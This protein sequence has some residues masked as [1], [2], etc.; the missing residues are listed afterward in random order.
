MK[1]C[2]CIPVQVG[3]ILI[4]IVGLL[5]CA[6]ELTLLVPYLMNPDACKNTTSTNSITRNIDPFKEN[7]TS[8]MSITGNIDPIKETLTTNCTSPLELIGIG[9]NM[10]ENFLRTELT[11]HYSEDEVMAILETYAKNVWPTLLT[12][13][14]EAGIYAFSCILVIVAVRCYG[15]LIIIFLICHINRMILCIVLG[16]GITVGFYFIDTMMCVGIGALIM[17]FFFIFGLPAIYSW[18][19]VK[20]AY[21][22]HE[23]YD[24]G[25]EQE[26]EFLNQE[27]AVPPGW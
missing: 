8:T 2:H 19:V 1:C 13:T 5:I 24:V 16:I 20:K 14:I 21:V 26:M 25:D 7:T 9:L 22:A 3:A 11:K 6:M 23:T 4:A 17:W 10:F 12:L 18:N 15:K 27:S